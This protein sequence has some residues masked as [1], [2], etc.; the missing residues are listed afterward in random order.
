MLVLWAFD[1]LIYSQNLSVALQ[2]MFK[3]IVHLH[4]LVLIPCQ[5]LPSGLKSHW[6]NPSKCSAALFSESVMRL[7]IT[8]TILWQFFSNQCMFWR[9][10]FINWAVKKNWFWSLHKCCKTF[11]PASGIAIKA[12]LILKSRTVCIMYMLNT[13]PN[14]HIT[15]FRR[16]RI[17]EH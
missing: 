3:L 9:I 1:H 6:Q 13:L 11:L 2:L 15:A 4:K 12:G 5:N 7:C 17:G 14:I 10:F 16:Y 8:N